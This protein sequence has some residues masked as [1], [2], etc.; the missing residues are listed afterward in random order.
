MSLGHRAA[1]ADLLWADLQVT[2]GLRLFEKRRYDLVVEAFGGKGYHVEDPADLVPTLRAA[3]AHPGV[4]CV[5]V[6]V[7]PD[8]VVKS[9]AA[10]LT[11]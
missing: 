10:K 7:D 3:L 6:S 1:V 9:G 4:T 2:Q 8:F 5:N 11:V